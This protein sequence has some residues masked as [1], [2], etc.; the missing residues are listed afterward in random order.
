MPKITSMPTEPYNITKWTIRDYDRKVSQLEQM[1]RDVESLKAAS[2]DGMPKSA[3]GPGL[4][5][6]IAAMVDL[7]KE[8]QKIQKC[9]D[10]LPPDMR[11]GVMNNIRYGMDYPRNDCGNYVP[12]KRTWKRVKKKFMMLVAKELHIYGHN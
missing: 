2:N 10:T 11:D 12:S 8:V 7:E 1:K 5:D 4:D 3:N 6:K 9:I